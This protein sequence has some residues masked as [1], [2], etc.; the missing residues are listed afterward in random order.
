MVDSNASKYVRATYHI[1]MCR[2]QW[3][4]GLMRGSV[5]V[6]RL[7]LWV[8]IPPGAW[9]IFYCECCVLS[10]RGLCVELMTY[11][12]ESYR[13]WCVVVCDLETSRIRS[14]HA[15][16]CN[17]TGKICV[18]KLIFVFLFFSLHKFEIILDPIGYIDFYL[19]LSQG[20]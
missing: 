20:G 4:R 11:P 2:S 18:I 8:R 16:G 1:C 10:C 17:P 7:R 5:A 13:L 12:E 15:L 9:M 6:R 3:P 14:W 19:F